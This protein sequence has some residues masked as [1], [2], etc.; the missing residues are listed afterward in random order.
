[1]SRPLRT[2]RS[3]STSTTFSPTEALVSAAALRFRDAEELE[4]ALTRAGFVVEHI[5]GGWNREPVGSGDGELLVVARRPRLARQH[6]P[7][8]DGC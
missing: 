6:V 3:P 4:G 7:Q 5:Y 2:A 8:T 1:M